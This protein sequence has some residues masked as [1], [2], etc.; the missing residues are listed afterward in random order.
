[1]SVVTFGVAS[2]PYQAPRVLKQVALDEGDKYPLAARVVANDFYMDDLN[3]GEDTVAAG[4]ILRGEL[5]DMTESAGYHLCKWSASDPG[6]LH[7]VP[8][9][10]RQMQ[11]TLDMDH[12]K[13]IT[14]TLG[15]HWKPASDRFLYRV[16]FMSQDSGDV[17]KRQ[18]LSESAR[19]FDPLGLLTPTTMIAKVMFQSLW[20]L[21]LAW[22][23]NLPPDILHHWLA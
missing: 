16:N 17:A 21:G 14:K 22:E 8:E 20:V 12:D 7:G 15:I 23:D 3:T 13:A 5:T 2:S 11:E 10:D 9:A 18:L 19:V 4:R 6:V 1:M